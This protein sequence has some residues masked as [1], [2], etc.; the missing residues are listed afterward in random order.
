VVRGWRRKDGSSRQLSAGELRT[1][2]DIQAKQQEF[3]I[4]NPCRVLVDAHYEGGEVRKQCAKFGWFALM[5]E[6]RQSYPHPQG[7]SRPPI[8]RLYSEPKRIDVGIGTAGQGRR[9]CVEFFFANPTAQDILQKRIDNP[10]DLKWELPSDASQECL[11]HLKGCVLV[12]DYDKKTGA[13]KPYWKKIGAEDLRD[14]E[15]MQIVAA[16]MARCIVLDPNEIPEEKEE[17]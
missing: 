10:T 8:Y 3:N 16:S 17:S 9:F 12:K 14:C 15:K 5:G 13:F 2:G 11:E 1:W 7:K 4:T 6:D